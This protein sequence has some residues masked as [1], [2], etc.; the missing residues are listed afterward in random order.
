MYDKSKPGKMSVEYRCWVRLKQ[1]C[2]NKNHQDYKNYGG[3]GIAVCKLWRESFAAFLK[4][5][6]RKPSLDLS[7]DRIDNDGNYEPGNCRWATRSQQQRNKRP[8]MTGRPR[9]YRNPRRLTVVASTDLYGRIKRRAKAE[10]RSLNAM[11][12]KLLGKA[13]GG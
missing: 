4:D 13:L 12:I 8:G 5:V 9:L 3:R 2:Y 7:L 10:D 11:A 1:R 6:G